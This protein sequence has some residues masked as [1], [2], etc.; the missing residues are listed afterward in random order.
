MRQKTCDSCVALSGD[1]CLL[2]FKNYRTYKK[3]ALGTSVIM[4]PAEK[5]PKPRSVKKFISLITIGQ[6]AT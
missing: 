1:G 5:C 4:M 6:Q 3:T 2:K